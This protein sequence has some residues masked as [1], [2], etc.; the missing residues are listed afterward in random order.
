MYVDRGAFF[1]GHEKA[2]LA[3]E[4]LG[5]YVSLTS[6][7]VVT[8]CIIYIGTIL[9]RCTQ[10]VCPDKFFLSGSQKDWKQNRQNWS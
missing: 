1:C 2:F 9:R 8:H 10:F 7:I 5:N 3:L 4:S 6:E